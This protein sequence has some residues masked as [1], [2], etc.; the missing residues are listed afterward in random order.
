MITAVLNEKVRR[1]KEKQSS[2]DRKSLE[3]G[4]FTMLET[5]SQKIKRGECKRRALKEDRK[6][7]SNA[8]E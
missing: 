1:V 5:K 6:R 2:L 8:K 4:S 3:K 7:M